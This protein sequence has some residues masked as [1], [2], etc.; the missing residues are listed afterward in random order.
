MEHE[1]LTLSEVAKYLKVSDKTIHRMINDNAI[2]CAK[3]GGQWRFLK[4]MIDDWLMSQMNVVSNNEYIRTLQGQKDAV[5]IARLIDPSCV[6][7]E[8]NPASGQSILNYLSISLE[9]AGVLSDSR[10]F[11]VQLMEREKIMSTGL[12]RG[13]AV[14]HPRTAGVAPVLHSGVAVGY[15]PEGVDFG[16]L[17]GQKTHLFF[18]IASSSDSIHVRILSTLVRIASEDGFLDEIKNITKANDLI[19]MILEKEVEIH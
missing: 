4:V 9:K 16:A 5:S 12:G 3:I 8:L 11:V 7:L 1:V 18:L 15:C 14:P 13:I 19:N 2:P 17:D 6:F 10:P